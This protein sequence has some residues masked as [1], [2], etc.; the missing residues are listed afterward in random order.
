MTRDC[1]GLWELGTSCDSCVPALGR[2]EIGRGA[3]GG[4]GGT[5]Y[6]RPDGNGGG[7]PGFSWLGL[8]GLSSGLR[9]GN[10]DGEGGRGGGMG[11]EV[12]VGIVDSG[13]G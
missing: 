3:V 1:G 8:P 10:G 11:V 4:G 9:E 12:S 2:K 5:P 7:G 13:A 6:G